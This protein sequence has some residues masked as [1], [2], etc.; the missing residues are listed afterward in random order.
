M[1]ESVDVGRPPGRANMEARP[2]VARGVGMPPR[3]CLFFAR[4][5]VVGRALEAARTPASED[6]GVL[7]AS[8]DVAVEAFRTGLT[9]P[10]VAELAG[11]D[12]L[13]SSSRLMVGGPARLLR[14][15]SR[16]AGREAA[17][18]EVGLLPGVTEGGRTLRRDEA[19]E[20]VVEG[21]LDMVLAL[22]RDGVIA[23]E[24]SGTSEARDEGLLDMEEAGRATASVGGAS[25]MATTLEA[26]QKTPLLGAQ[27]K[28]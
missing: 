15:V 10:R 3:L 9:C 11:R 22:L 20:G 4:L 21:G 17:R 6:L 25:L 1:L 8:V 24:R 16:L 26:G 7:T 28:Y 23:P 14:A 12:A 19:R 27:A 5:G 18:A 13:S 2:F